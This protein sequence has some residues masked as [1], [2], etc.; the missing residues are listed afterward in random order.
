MTNEMFDSMSAHGI[1][2]DELLLREAVK[3]AG[4]R[5]GTTAAMTIYVIKKLQRLEQSRLAKAKEEA[6]RP[7][8]TAGRHFKR[9]DG[10]VINT[11]TGD[12]TLIARHQAEHFFLSLP[13]AFQFNLIDQISSEVFPS[14][15]RYGDHPVRINIDSSDLPDDSWNRLMLNKGEENE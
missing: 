6:R 2:R 9:P 1:N 14:H 8:E 15:V 12:L 13:F 11:H 10:Q 7:P 5:C 3:E 4:E